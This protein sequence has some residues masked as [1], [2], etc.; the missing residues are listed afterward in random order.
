MLYGRQSSNAIR[1]SAATCQGMLNFF[2]LI[3]KIFKLE[4]LCGLKPIPHADYVDGYIKAFYLPE[5]GL[6][7]WIN[8]HTVF[9]VNF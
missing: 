8:Q 4:P 7:Q 3:Q 9:Y 2:L 5:N 6:E 1:F